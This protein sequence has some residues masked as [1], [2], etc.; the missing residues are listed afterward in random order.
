MQ[1]MRINISLDIDLLNG[2][3][4]QA[5]ETC[6]SCT[7]GLV[8]KTAVHQAATADADEAISSMLLLA[9]V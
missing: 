2:H 6:A 8:V 7:S 5:I 1:C 3:G 4:W 9:Y